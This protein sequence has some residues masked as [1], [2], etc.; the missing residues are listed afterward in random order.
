MTEWLACRTPNHT[1]LQVP[2]TRK[3]VVSPIK[4]PRGLRVTTIVPRFAQPLMSRPTSGDRQRWSYT[5]VIVIILITVH[6]PKTCSACS[7]QFKA[8]GER[9]GSEVEE[10]K[11]ETKMKRDRIEKRVNSHFSDATNMTHVQRQS[12]G[13]FFFSV[14]AAM[15]C[16]TVLCA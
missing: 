15:L 11:L 5:I 9:S 4:V 3:T 16:S 12:A 10:Y 1:K 14:R 8:K 6:M 2:V 7:V 13:L